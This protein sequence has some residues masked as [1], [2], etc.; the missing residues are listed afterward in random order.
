MSKRTETYDVF[1]DIKLCDK[2]LD[3][4]KE[5]LKTGRLSPIT[6]HAII[7]KIN[8]YLDLISE[9]IDKM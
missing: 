6:A 3:K 4:V 7:V 9:D 1:E 2:L 5:A 8:D